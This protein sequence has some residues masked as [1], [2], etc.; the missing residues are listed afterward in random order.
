MTPSD[1]HKALVEVHDTFPKSSKMFVGFIE[2][3]SKTGAF[4]GASQ[5]GSVIAMKSAWQLEDKAP[6]VTFAPTDEGVIGYVRS[7]AEKSTQ[8]PCKMLVVIDMSKAL[9]SVW[10]VPKGMCFIATAALGDAFA[11]E[12]TVLSAFRD[13]VLLRS[14]IG[15]TFVRLYYARSPSIA[16]VIAR[17]AFLRRAAM[18]LIVR[19]SVKLVQR[20]SVKDGRWN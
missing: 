6:T 12:I 14:Q 20:W 8:S 10:V 9:T 11:P 5:R 1:I 4:D 18:V 19:P 7:V 15:R 3:A 13:D 2:Q 16:A 17:S